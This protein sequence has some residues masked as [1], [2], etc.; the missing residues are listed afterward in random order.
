M[1]VEMPVMKVVHV[2]LVLDGGMP[3]AL[4]VHVVVAGMFGKDH[5]KA[6]VMIAVAVVGMMEDPVDEVIHVVS[7]GNGGMAAGRTVHVGAAFVGIDAAGGEFFRHLDGMLVHVV[8]MGAVEVSVVEEAH[9][10]IVDDL[11]VPAAFFVLVVSVV[12][13]LGA[14][15][16][17]LSVVIAVGRVGMVEM[18]VD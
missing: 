12:A 13:V 16:F 8:I 3:A 9:V 2:A 6:S 4:L 10:A 1:V 14:F 7:V 18:P 11:G 5:L 15:L 17:H